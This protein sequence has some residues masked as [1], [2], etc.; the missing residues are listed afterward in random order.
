[1]D[2]DTGKFKKGDIE[3]TVIKVNGEHI[4]EKPIEAERKSKTLLQTKPYTFTASQFCLC[5]KGYS[6][7]FC[8]LFSNSIVK[9]NSKGKSLF[10]RKC[11]FK[12]FFVSVSVVHS[13]PESHKMGLTEQKVLTEKISRDFSVTELKLNY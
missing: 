8:L 7:N 9:N 4:G 1:M 2:N 11:S 3:L 10:I 12:S 13:L 5:E 6:K